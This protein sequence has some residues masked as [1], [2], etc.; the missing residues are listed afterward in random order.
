MKDV[1]LGINCFP[2]NDKYKFKRLLTSLLVV[3]YFPDALN[4][5]F[6]INKL[7]VKLVNELLKRPEYTP[8]VINK[9]C[10]KYV[11]KILNPKTE[12][13]KLPQELNEF[14][15]VPFSFNM[16]IDTEFYIITKD[17]T[18]LPVI[19]QVA[20]VIKGWNT[21]LIYEHLPNKSSIKE[22]IDYLINNFNFKPISSDKI[23]VEFLVDR[24]ENI[25]QEF[26]NIINEFKS[27]Y[28]GKVSVC[29]TVK[30][31]NLMINRNIFMYRHLEDY[32]IF[33]DD[34]DVSADLDSKLK[35]VDTYYLYYGKYDQFR[36]EKYE[37]S[38]EKGKDLT[39]DYKNLYVY[40]TRS[41]VKYVKTIGFA[42]GFYNC[43]IPNHVVN[44]FTGIN[45][46]YLEDHIFSDIY[47][48]NQLNCYDLMY[49]TLDKSK[50]DYDFNDSDEYMFKLNEVNYVKGRLEC[51]TTDKKKYVNL[52]NDD[53]FKY[54]DT[55]EYSIDGNIIITKC[56]EII[57]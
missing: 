32:K 46:V 5:G 50:N 29:G 6:Q 10:S 23:C 27:L 18:F 56:C 2:G 28:K 15:S 12:M 45:N 24:T 17:K 34:D 47:K 39:L 19:Q 42:N 57:N 13:I 51:N 16:D 48:H 7:V 3:P 22:M 35:I 26:E 43:I 21:V 1:Y 55:F 41:Y 44:C 4:I 30:K 52:L 14:N 54:D 20:S 36:Q 37:E 33:C 40:I 25:N 9:I 31:T 49:Y 11:L 8:E 53:K 38:K